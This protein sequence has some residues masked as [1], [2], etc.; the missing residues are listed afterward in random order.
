VFYCYPTQ[1][2]ATITALTRAT[3]NL[4][5]FFASRIPHGMVEKTFLPTKLLGGSVMRV[6]DL[7]IDI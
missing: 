3:I 5:G 2:I 7:A 6:Y 1:T 4:A